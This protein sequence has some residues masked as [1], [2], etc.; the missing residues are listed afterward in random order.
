MVFA[1]E[2]DGLPA[3]QPSLWV[4][5]VLEVASCCCCS[6]ERRASPQRNEGKH[7]L[8]NRRFHLSV[9]HRGSAH[10][11]AAGNGESVPGPGGHLE[12]PIGTPKNAKKHQKNASIR[13]GCRGNVSD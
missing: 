8:G 9:V 6:G 2:D 12:T 11:A 13:G 10:M 1:L 4:V 3:E 5:C 7:A